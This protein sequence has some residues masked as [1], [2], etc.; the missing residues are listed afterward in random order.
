MARVHSVG[1]QR[2]VSLTERWEVCSTVPDACPGPVSVGGPWLAACV[3]GTVAGALR[4]AGLWTLEE[5]AP[6]HGMDFWFRTT[7]QAAGEQTLRFHGLATLTEVW[8][9]GDKLLDSDN[10]F[11]AHDVPARCAGENELLLCF[12]ALQPVLDAKQGRARWRPPMMDRAAPRSVRTTLLGHLPGWCPPVHAIGPWRPVELVETAGPLRVTRADVRTSVTDGDGMLALRLEVQWDG[13]SHPDACIDLAGNRAAMTWV[14]PG[15][16][17]GT[18]RAPRVQPWW[19]HT[20]GEPALY[21]LRALVGNLEVDLGRV[22]FRALAVD[23]GPDGRGFALKVNGQ[24]IFARGAC[25][26]SADLVSLGGT[27]EVYEPWLI[28]MR[29]AGMNLVRVGGTMVYESNAFFELCDELGLMV[30]QDFMFA[31]CDYPVADEAFARSVRREAQQLLDRTQTSPALAVLCGG[32]EVEQ[33][34][35]MLGH[36]KPVWK[37]SLFDELLPSEVFNA[38]ADVLYVPNSPFGGELPFS[39][40]APVTHYYGVGAYFRPLEDARRAGVHFAAECLAFAN[41]PESATLA[42]VLPAGDAPPGH[43][44]WKARVPRDIGAAWDFDDVRDHY[45]G[46]LYQVDPAALRRDDPDRYLRMSRAV[47]G[48]AMEEV[49]A[50]WRR[51]RSTCK[52]GLVWLFQDL[53]PGAGW[54]VVDSLGAPKSAWHAL[55]RAFR[56][57]QVTLSDEGLNGLVLHVHNETPDPLDATLSLACLR[58]GEVPVV[59]GARDVTVAARSSVEIAA[60]ALLDSFFDTSDAYRFGPPQHDVTVAALH[61]RAGTR[62]A[63]AF[64]FARGRG[65]ERVALGLSAAIEK[66]SG[67]WTLRLKTKRLA[68]SVHVDDDHYRAEPE[69]FHLPPGLERIVSLTPRGCSDAVPDGEIHALNGLAPVRYRGHIA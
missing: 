58:A 18:I 57:V 53:W 7:F 15:T 11:L 39:A 29:D 42:R 28:R 8:L 60:A 52:G 38:R 2:I 14:G 47:T 23:D 6:L 36:R 64:H 43:P 26:S 35:A 37:S 55:Q 19:P 68:Q 27:R 63:D 65:S 41:V 12:R 16:L 21:P 9:N 32:S 13:R 24:T 3:P 1:G 34:A 54:G 51:A 56:P 25:W 40:D 67:G 69:W 10:M 48:E 62:I 49:F 22:G 61:D 17:G 46:R 33:Q 50:E 45:L 44:K 4:H 30:W 31:N 5:P 20:H 59:H 66:T